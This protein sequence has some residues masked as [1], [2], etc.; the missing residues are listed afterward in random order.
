MKTQIRIVIA[1]LISAGCLIGAGCASTYST[2]TKDNIEI[3]GWRTIPLV[4]FMPY[5]YTGLNAGTSESPLRADQTIILKWEDGR[6]V[7]SS[8]ITRPIAEMLCPTAHESTGEWS[9]WKTNNT[10]YSCHPYFFTFIGNRL[11]EVTV[12]AGG[13]FSLGDTNRFVTLPASERAL[14]NVIGKPDKIENEFR[15]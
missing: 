1:S 8:E 6:L 5:S 3:W 14:R 15:F 7:T 2:I 13:E 9:Q 11:V 4:P 10:T 12:F